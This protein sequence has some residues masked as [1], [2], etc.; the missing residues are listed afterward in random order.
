MSLIDTI[1]DCLQIPFIEENHAVMDGSF[2]VTPYITDSLF[3]NSVPQ[4]ISVY[5]SVDLFYEKRTDAVNNGIKLFKA[6][7]NAQ[8]IFCDNPDFTFEQDAN[9]WRTTLMVQEVLND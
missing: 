3:G 4:S 1:K 7:N 2:T 5:S 9:L 6:L 8:N